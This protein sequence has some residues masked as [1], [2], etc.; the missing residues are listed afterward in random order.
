MSTGT[1]RIT[2][3][4]STPTS[5]RISSTRHEDYCPNVQV[6]DLAKLMEQELKDAKIEVENLDKLV[7]PDNQLPFIIT[8]KLIKAVQWKIPRSRKEDAIA[9]WLNDVT[10]NLAKHTKQGALR[11]W[12]SCMKNM[13]AAGS[14]IKRKPD[15]VVVG[16]S[17]RANK[18][19]GKPDW[20][21]FHAYTEVTSQP[22]STKLEETTW[23]KSFV[24]F[25]AQPTRRF[26]PSLAFNRD[27]A[28]FYVCD[29]A[30]VV[31]SKTLKLVNNKCKNELLRLIAGFAF[32]PEHL[33]GYDPTMKRSGNKITTIT[34]K[35]EEYTVDKRLFTSVTMRGRA[36]Q[37]WTVCSKDGKRY[38]LKD[39]WIDI[40]RQL[41]EIA[42][43]KEISDVANVPTLIEG[44]DVQ[45]PDGTMD[46]TNL[47]RPNGQ[48]GEERIHRRLLIMEVGEPL[49]TFR[50]KKE[51]IG[52]FIDVVKGKHI[53]WLK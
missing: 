30:G 47:R 6:T 18:G 8:K 32:G 14:N 17:F 50:S 40:R 53:F 12:D 10:M 28:F 24:M 41:N 52:A 9:R 2:S 7:F 51:L 46:T 34:V 27:H 48:S 35:E 4:S 25:E 44:W 3:F 29:R 38:I 45:L 36:T 11:K 16:K 20:R 21:E 49:G 15:I 1:T 23:Q 39:S 31:Y 42:I 22:I 43:L 37:C 26:I 33:L 13:V 19:A 5:Q